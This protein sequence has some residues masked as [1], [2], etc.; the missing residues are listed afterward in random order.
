MAMEAWARFSTA[1]PDFIH[2]SDSHMQ[3]SA[4]ALAEPEDAILFFSYSGSTKDMCDT[5]SIASQKGIP[6]ILITH[7]PKSAGT[8]YATVVLQCGY[9]ESPLQSGS[10][11]A[12]VG[13][14]FL[15]DCLFYGYCSLKPELRSAARSAQL[16]QLLVNCCSSISNT[17]TR[18]KLAREHF[19]I[20]EIF[21]NDFL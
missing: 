7:F 21:Q 4:T 10:V 3:A 9:N 6:V 1:S 2:I 8:E 13:Q 11:A 15:I 16:K 18:K 20:I 12:K 14:L 19:Y 17:V 5:L